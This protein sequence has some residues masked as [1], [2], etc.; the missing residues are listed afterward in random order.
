MQ[1]NLRRA[2]MG[3]ASGGENGGR[4]WP[5]EVTPGPHASVMWSWDQ[6]ETAMS[7]QSREQL[8]Y[9]VCASFF[10]KICTTVCKHLDFSQRKSIF[11][12]GSVYVWICVWTVSLSRQTNSWSES[13]R[14]REKKN[15]PEHSCPL[16]AVCSSTSDC[17]EEGCDCG[18]GTLLCE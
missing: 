15:T 11:I 8:R 2:A 4:S 6:R 16:V 5:C 12:C 1:L 17:A 10:I 14:E 18:R 13:M 7:S 9:D 3:A